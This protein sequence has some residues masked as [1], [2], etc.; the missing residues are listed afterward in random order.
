MRIKLDSIGTVLSVI[1]VTQENCS[2]RF[3]KINSDNGLKGS[4]MKD[5]ENGSKT[6]NS[7]CHALSQ[8]KEFG[9]FV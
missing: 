4:K 9:S 2:S 7:S 8:G 1:S 5:R 3:G 6:A